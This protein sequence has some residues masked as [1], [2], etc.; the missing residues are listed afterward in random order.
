M[1][2]SP[3]PPRRAY[4]AR[5]TVALKRGCVRQ[6][7]QEQ[8]HLGSTMKNQRREPEPTPSRP[9]RPRRKARTPSEFARIYGSKKRVEFVKGLPCAARFLGG[10]PCSRGPSQNAHTET[11]GMG[12]KADARTILP[13]CATHHDCYDQHHTPFDDVSVRDRMKAAAGHLDAMYQLATST[14]TAA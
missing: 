5:G 14:E 11:G 8:E 3:L 6:Q 10:P 12:R 4:I 13:F 1:K 7:Q 2:R 9:V